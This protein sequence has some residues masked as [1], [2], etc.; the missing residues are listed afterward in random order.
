MGEPRKVF[1]IEGIA[2]ARRAVRT[3][4]TTAAPGYAEVMQELSALRAL[5]APSVESATTK[6]SQRG[7]VQRL[8]AALTLIHD[9]LSGEQRERSV[10]KC[11]APMTHIAHELEAV[12][13]GSEEATQK[14]LAAAEDIDQVAD[15][16][17][18]ALKDEIDRGLAQD[19]RDRVVHIFEACNFQDLTGQ[20]ISKVMTTMK[21]IEN[22]ITVM[23][24]IWGG[25]DA[26]KAH[27]PPIVDD[28][29]DEE[30]LLNG[31]KL[32][33]DAGH[34]SQNDIDALFN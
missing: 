28:R 23:M 31:P 18:A 6:E 5:I 20:R 7:S 3:E 12:S 2:A 8:A 1:R 14:I 10:D 4:D 15:N 16:L 29:P 11:L 19:I 30:K 22:H 21:F 13:K 27:A 25:V 33:G 32:D 9:A 24:D 34:A 17:T 26:I